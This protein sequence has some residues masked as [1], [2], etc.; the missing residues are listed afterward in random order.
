VKRSI[1]ALRS[2]VY[3]LFIINHALKYYTLQQHHI[4]TQAACKYFIDKRCMSSITCCIHPIY[5]QTLHKL[6][7]TR[8]ITSSVHYAFYVP[9]VV[10]FVSPCSKH[11][12]RRGSSTTSLLA[13]YPCSGASGGKFEDILLV[14]DEGSHCLEATRY[15]LRYNKE[16]DG[17]GVFYSVLREAT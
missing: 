17:N 14:T 13:I 11:R 2:T 9:F 8:Q 16:I 5:L 10:Q 4:T 6:H 1:S 3:P 7:T 15:S 12:N